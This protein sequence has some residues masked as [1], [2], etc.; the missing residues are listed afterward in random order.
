MAACMY[1]KFSE[2][3]MCG[4]LRYMNGHIYRYADRNTSHAYQ[5]QS[6]NVTAPCSN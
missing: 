4:F 6:E 2:V 5:G 1:K 3:C